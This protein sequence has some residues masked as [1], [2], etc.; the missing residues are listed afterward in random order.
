MQRRFEFLDVIVVVGLCATIVAS[1]VLL[2]AANGMQIGSVGTGTIG[3]PTDNLTGMDLLQPVLGQAIVDHVLLE[4]RHAKDAAAAITQLGGLTFERNQWQHF[5]YSYLD[6]VTTGASWAESEHTA[7]VQTVMG[8][9]IVNFTRRGV[10][11]GLWSSVERAAHDNPKMIGVTKAMGQ[12]MDRLFLANW[13]PNIGRGIVAATQENETRST[14]R[15]EQLG[16][17]ILEMATV[18]EVYE[19]VRAA[20]QEQL[21]S[22]TVVATMPG[23]QQ[24]GVTSDRLTADRV[25]ALS[26]QDALP[27]ISTTTTFLVASLILISLFTT[28]LFVL[29]SRRAEVPQNG[30]VRALVPPKLL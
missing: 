14:L 13:Q 29:S 11:S 23:S 5:P 24:R 19:P 10:R 7:R 6:P 12:N 22:A 21:G 27:R 8:R 20:I 4:R 26:A 28:G 2:M 9:S 15:Q 1:G 16:T 18:Q 3:Q 25:A 17:A 30:L